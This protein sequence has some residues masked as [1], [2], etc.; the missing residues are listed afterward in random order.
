MTQTKDVSAEDACRQPEGNTMEMGR[1]ER[2]EHFQKQK[3][4]GWPY[5]EPENL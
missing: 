5:D 2:D 4:L 3:L 1:S